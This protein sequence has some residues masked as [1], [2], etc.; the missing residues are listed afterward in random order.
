[1]CED[2]AGGKR[3]DGSREFIISHTVRV[4]LMHYSRHSHLQT[5]RTPNNNI[6]TGVRCVKSTGSRCVKRIS[7]LLEGAR[8]QDVQRWQ[9]VRCVQRTGTGC[10]KRTVGTLFEEGRRQVV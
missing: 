8:G 4:S 10:V 1:M 2:G 6:S 5:T 3:C 7:K 9:A